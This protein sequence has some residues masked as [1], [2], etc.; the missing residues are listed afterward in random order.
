MRTEQQAFENVAVA[1]E[2]AKLTKDN[3][4]ANMNANDMKLLSQP[5]KSAGANELP[6]LEIIGGD[7]TA[8]M[9]PADAIA[10]LSKTLKKTEAPSEVDNN[11]QQ[12]EKQTDYAKRSAEADKELKA[13]GQ[14][15]ESE[16]PVKEF[17][18][19]GDAANNQNDK[20]PGEE[21][22]WK[23]QPSQSDIEK[24]SEAPLS[25]LKSSKNGAL[26]DSLITK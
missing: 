3:G 2:A 5:G 10:Q 11:P 6:G 9:T 7:K 1:P 26:S 14:K 18:K 23:N 22:V 21:R 24:G 15:Q 20:A 16:K 25:H 12:A 4:F 13:F 8:T 19:S 17:T